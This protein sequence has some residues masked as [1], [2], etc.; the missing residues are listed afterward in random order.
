MSRDAQI[1]FPWADGDFTFRLGWGE[2]ELLQEACNAG[3]YVI[4]NRLY[5][6]SWRLGD[7]SHTLRIGLMGGG[8]KPVD[9]LNKVRAYVENRPPMENLVFAQAVLSAGLVGA[10]EEKLGEDEAAN[11]ESVSTISQTGN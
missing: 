7:I 10:P 5:D 3:P 11:Q 4:L 1:T 9:A 6:E 8:M 2:L